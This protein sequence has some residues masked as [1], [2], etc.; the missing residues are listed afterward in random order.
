[1]GLEHGD[2]DDV[3][4]EIDLFHAIARYFCMTDYERDILERA[5][6]PPELIARRK[7]ERLAGK[8]DDHRS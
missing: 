2:Q 1:M 8:N 3:Q 5:L 7:A 6:L 4:E